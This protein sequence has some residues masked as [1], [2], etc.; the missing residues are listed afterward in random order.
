MRFSDS[1]I[2]FFS[3]PLE[4]LY[5][6]NVTNKKEAVITGKT[7][8]LIYKALRDKTCKKDIDFSQLIELGFVV[9]D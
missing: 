6:L 1:V 8:A 9:D 4:K 5:M 2:Y 7:A 3:R